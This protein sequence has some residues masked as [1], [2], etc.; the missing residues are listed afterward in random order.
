M[1]RRTGD[2]FDLAAFA[3]SLDALV[4]VLVELL[5]VGAQLGVLR[6]GRGLRKL[7]GET[8]QGL[9][10][11]LVHVGL[12]VA[13][14][15]EDFTGATLFDASATVQDTLVPSASSTRVGGGSFSIRSLPD[16][17]SFVCPEVAQL[18]EGLPTR[19]DRAC[20]GFLSGV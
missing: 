5:E 16:V 15:S 9:L 12:K 3:S 11:E 4:A 13:Q 17:S 6:V 14:L 19:R 18:G 1:S 20:V 8:G 7:L 2:D 10:V